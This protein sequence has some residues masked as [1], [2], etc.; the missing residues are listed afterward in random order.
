[1][2]TRSFVRPPLFR[3]LERA[4]VRVVRSEQTTAE[5]KAKG[6]KKRQLIFELTEEVWRV[7]LPFVA[8]FL[9]REN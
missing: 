1:M 9:G 4:D 6:A 2:A 3:F 8:S 7:R 5:D